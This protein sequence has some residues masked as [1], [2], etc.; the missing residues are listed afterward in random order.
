MNISYAECEQ[1]IG[2]ELAAQVK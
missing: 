1:L 2:A